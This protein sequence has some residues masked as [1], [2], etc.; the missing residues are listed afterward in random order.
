MEDN[1]YIL[2]FFSERSPQP[3]AAT[4]KEPKRH[5]YDPSGLPVETTFPGEEVR[6]ACCK[7]KQRDRFALGRSGLAGSSIRQVKGFSICTSCTLLS[8]FPPSSVAA[9]VTAS[10]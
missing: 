4:P 1:V 5:R 8:T 6:S 3:I 10:T 9:T 7:R 2:I